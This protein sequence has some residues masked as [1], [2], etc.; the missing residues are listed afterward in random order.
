MYLFAYFTA[1]SALF[2]GNSQTKDHPNGWSFVWHSDS[3][4]LISCAGI[5]SFKHQ[6]TSIYHVPFL[7]ALTLQRNKKKHGVAG[8]NPENL[9]QYRVF[10]K[11]MKP[12]THLMRS[13][14]QHT[15]QSGRIGKCV[16]D[17]RNLLHGLVFERV[18]CYSIVYN[19][20]KEHQEWKFWHN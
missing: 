20:A 18:A 13:N 5:V 10:E 14:E 15:I 4:R 17:G 3:G 7:P 19:R 12:I 9:Y 1:E 2:A 8:L 16:F 11:R 6:K